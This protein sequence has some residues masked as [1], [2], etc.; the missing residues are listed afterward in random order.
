MLAKKKNLTFLPQFE[1]LKKTQGEVI[2]TVNTYEQNLREL[3][4][5]PGYLERNSN[6]VVRCLLQATH[7]AYKKKLAIRSIHPAAITINESLGTVMFT[8]MR[9]ITKALVHDKDKGTA[10]TPYNSNSFYHLRSWSCADPWRD[11]WSMGILMLEILVGWKVVLSQS[12]F[13]PI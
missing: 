4:A 8:D 10:P 6:L 1:S 2:L 3:M 11:H 7:D 13:L 12:K 5:D 9:S